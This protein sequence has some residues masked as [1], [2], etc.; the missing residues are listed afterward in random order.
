[1][2]KKHFLYTTLSLIVIYVWVLYSFF[3]Y[4]HNVYQN[5]G[6]SLSLFFNFL[7][8]VF[9]A[10]CLGVIMLLLRMMWF[11]NQKQFSLKDSFVYIFTGIFNLNLSIIWSI[12]FAMGYLK[13]E[14]EGW[15]YYLG[16][17]VITVWI[18]VDVYVFR[19]SKNNL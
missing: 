6:G 9:L 15:Y 13:L 11:R 4:H 10:Q 19:K 2:D 3:D 17:V 7:G 1:M 8:S 5:N 16:N 14:A 18:L 12:T